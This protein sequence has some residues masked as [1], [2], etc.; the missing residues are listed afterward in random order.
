[1]P[2]GSPSTQY[3][4]RD[5]SG[6]AGEPK[7]AGKD[8]RTL[9]EPADY[10]GNVDQFV[11]GE[12]LTATQ[13]PQSTLG[14][15]PSSALFFPLLNQR[16]NVAVAGLY[17]CT[18]LVIV[19][20]QG[21]WMSHFFEVPS[22]QNQE[23]FKTQVLD[24]L[25]PGD[26]TSNMPGL[27]QYL[28]EGKAFGPN[29]NPRAFI[30]TP[31]DRI[32]PQ[33]NVYMYSDMIDQLRDSI[34]ALFRNG[35]SPFVADPTEPGS[36]KSDTSSLEFN[37][38]ADE[39]KA[40]LVYGYIPKHP[41][42]YPYDQGFTSAG[43]LLFQFDPAQSYC[44]DEHGTVQQWALTR[45]WFEDNVFY[46]WKYAWLARANQ[47]VQYPANGPQLPTLSSLDD[48]NVPLTYKRR[49]NA[50]LIEPTTLPVPAY[51]RHPRRGIEG[52]RRQ[53]SMVS[54]S[55]PGPACWAAITGTMSYPVSSGIVIGGP[56]IISET[57]SVPLTMTALSITGSITPTTSTSGATENV[58]PTKKT[59]S[60]MSITSTA[61]ASITSG[62]SCMGV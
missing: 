26:G 18:S 53:A 33:P 49:D 42:L 58:S 56:G 55:M 59:S 48:P 40:I 15:P 54:V 57:A 3:L 43:K 32:N 23:N 35:G 8:K 52:F 36:P 47:I 38:P 9:P 1:M 45:L 37:D 39:G 12:Y 5:L 27:N 50:D 44:M 60:A 2:T 20:T 19:S 46:I 17:G 30:I 16:L 14:Q 21:V 41:D 4:K 61:V 24:V 7:I 11:F 51:V 29:T 13:V 6:P 62:F 34:T 10:G 22:F 28:G 31:Q 25:G